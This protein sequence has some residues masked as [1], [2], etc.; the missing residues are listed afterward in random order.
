MKSILPYI[1]FSFFQGNKQLENGKRRFE[2][3]SFIMNPGDEL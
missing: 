1:Q 2:E 3:M